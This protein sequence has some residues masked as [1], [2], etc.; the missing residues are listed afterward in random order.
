MPVC[1]EECEHSRSDEDDGCAVSQILLR[2]P[3]AHQFPNDS[4]DADFSGY[5]FWLA[6][7]NEFGG[8]FVNAEMVKAFISSSEYRNRFG[9]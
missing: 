6:K 3:P 8:N 5:D 4:P 9:Q 2:Q 1:L 7:L